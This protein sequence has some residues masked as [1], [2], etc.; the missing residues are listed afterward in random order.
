ML[1]DLEMSPLNKSI[2]NVLTMLIVAPA[3]AVITL[4]NLHPA[5]WAGAE[6]FLPLPFTLILGLLM[7]PLLWLTYIPTVIVMPIA[8][9]RTAASQCFATLRLPWL[10]LLSGLLGGILG[11]YVLGP[12]AFKCFLDADSLAVDFLAA[13]AVAGATSLAIIC[14]IHRHGLRTA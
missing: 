2:L 7:M 3:V 11:A 1:S 13:G 6:A 14:L 9:R 12:V 10:I 5:Q 8:M 4:F